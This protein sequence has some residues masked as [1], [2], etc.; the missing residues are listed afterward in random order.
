MSHDA[1]TS[2]TQIFA[3]RGIGTVVCGAKARVDGHGDIVQHGAPQSHGPALA[4]SFVLSERDEG[5]V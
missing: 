2:S 1:Y 5:D 3:G 4:L